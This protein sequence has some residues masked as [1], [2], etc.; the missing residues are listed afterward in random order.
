MILTI[1]TIILLIVLP[2]LFKKAGVIL[3]SEKKKRGYFLYFMSKFIF[4][5]LLIEICYIWTGDYYTFFLGICISLFIIQ[6]H[7][8]REYIFPFVYKIKQQAE[9]KQLSGVRKKVPMV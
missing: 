1:I 9:R 5:I 4:W 7:A 6:V 2:M 3:I 8:K